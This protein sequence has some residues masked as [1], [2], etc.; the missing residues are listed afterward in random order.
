[1]NLTHVFAPITKSEKLAD[2]TMLVYG[3][4]TGA[5]LDL[6]QQ[7]C[8]PEWLRTAM[9]D[10]FKIGNIREM[11][12]AWA[13]GKALELDSDGDDWYGTVK[14]VD[15]EAIKKVE[16]GVY[17]GFSIGIK[18]PKTV[19]DA[20]APNGRIVA[21]KIIETSLADA[22]CNET[23]KILLAK[24]STTGDLEPTDLIVKDAGDLAGSTEGVE[25]A[26]ATDVAGDAAGTDADA[27]AVEDAAEE[28]VEI[29]LL[30]LAVAAIKQLLVG[31]ATELAEGEGGLGPV[32]ILTYVLSELEWFAEC[33]AYDDAAARIES[34]KAARTS[35]DLMN[36]T[37]L[38]TLTKAATADTAS[39]AD[40]TAVGELRKALGIDDI[41]T[42]LTEVATA[43]DLTKVADR[44]TK[45]ENTVVDVG[46]ARARTNQPN[47]AATD[48]LT[49]AAEYRRL[50]I[51][52][53]DREQAKAYVTLADQLE[54][55]PSR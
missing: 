1:M 12:Q 4:L 19:P 45:V 47:E 52:V 48:R 53:S 44:L 36:L 2:G 49:K 26:A 32:N 41:T 37:T 38:A 8:D 24:V 25:A 35:E 39:D 17:T 29:D 28:A 23:A 15:A 18:G 10:W 27:V 33:D 46:P 43:E 6:D 42:K 16:H 21:G 55:T 14:I 5:D 20:A 9:P 22:P 30:A 51:T 31:E 54:R 3:K 11:H 34:M 50:S 7:I 13:V 40:K